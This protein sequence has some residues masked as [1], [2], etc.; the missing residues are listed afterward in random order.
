LRRAEDRKKLIKNGFNVCNFKV[1]ERR[2]S[3]GEHRERGLQVPKV[4]FIN[5]N[6]VKIGGPL[7]SQR[8]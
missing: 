2:N 3:K 1:K 5:R 8:G 4:G 7:K 6:S